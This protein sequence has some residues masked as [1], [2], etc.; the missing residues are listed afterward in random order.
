[1]ITEVPA[2]LM[3]ENI[4]LSLTQNMQQTG[5]LVVVTTRAIKMESDCHQH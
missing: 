1:M 4:P 2:T 3:T 5:S